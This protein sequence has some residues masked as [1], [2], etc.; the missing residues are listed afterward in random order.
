MSENSKLRIYTERHILRNPALSVLMKISVDERF[1]ES[2]FEKALQALKNVHPLLY[3]SV[4]MDDD[5]V[6]Y[7]RENGVQ[8]LELHC[9]RREH[10][11][12]WLEVAEAE[13]KRPFDCETGPLVRFFVFYGEADFDILAVVQHLIGDGDAIARLLRDV[14]AAYAG[15]DLPRQEQVL[16]TS[17]RDLPPGATP[18][19]LTKM[20]VRPFNKMWNK[21][22][23]PRFREPEYRE[24]FYNYHR[25]A[26]IGLACSTITANQMKDLHRA[27]KANGVTINSAI[28][29]AFIRAMQ[30]RHYHD[31]N[32]KTVVGVP[33]NM[34]NRLSLPATSSLGNFAS[35]VSVKY[36]YNT[37]ESFWRNAVRVQTK[38]KSKLESDK[39]PWVLLNLYALM[40]PLLI[41]AMYFAAYGNCDD[42][43]ARKA[44]AML[45]I[46]NP[47]STAVSNLG[48]L[49]F[50]GQIGSCHVRDMVFFAPK[51]TG[52]YVVL[53]V[54]T[55][56]GTMQI[57]FSYDR[58]I[59]SS[60][61]M[62]D[63][64]SA[65]LE[66]LKNV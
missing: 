17:Q 35:A 24:M 29:T 21:G 31:K 18:T 28:V 27:C 11:N 6:A 50:D 46:D 13:N 64:G 10:S 41:D 61:T 3:S 36:R 9:I 42:K 53:G 34:R 44:A 7:Y 62:E 59:I 19:F 15:V 58:N 56:G 4:V 66:S 26:D 45:S 38:L 55:L 16:I 1:D 54:A 32:R 48:R 39:A 63:V 40:E 23:R 60:D 37:K 20:F 49:D 22:A 43:A 5:G 51:A 30:E 47:S 12:Q 65:M 14:V 8:R 33:I 25:T 2:R 52:S 57:G